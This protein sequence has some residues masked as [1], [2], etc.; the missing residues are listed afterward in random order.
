[1]FVRKKKN[2]S[3][4]ISIQ[5]IEK[6]GGKSVLV[7]TIGSSLEAKEIEKLFEQGKQFV[8]HYAGQQDLQ[9]E[10]E[11]ELVSRYFNSLQS[12]RLVGPELLLGKIFD[13]IGFNR[14]KDEL[15]RAL[16]ITRLIYPVSKLKTLDYLF[17]YKNEVID[18]E[19]IYS[20]P[21]N[22]TTSRRNRYKRSAT[23]TP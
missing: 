15:F 17:K 7:K 2:K 21:I 8:R 19:R 6:R 4:V 18:V 14:I 13:K 23:V 5:V 3:G 12:F 22:F 20:Y 10:D 11:Q 9:F 1:M 16:V